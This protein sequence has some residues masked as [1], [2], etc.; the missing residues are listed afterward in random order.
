MDVWKVSPGLN[1][2]YQATF[3]DSNGNPITFAGTEAL[4]G[5]VWAGDS[6]AALFTL[7]P[8]WATPASGSSMRRSQGPRRQTSQS[9]PTG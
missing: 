7:S 6:L 5:T 2:T 9:A 3:C 8:T 1:V 4:S